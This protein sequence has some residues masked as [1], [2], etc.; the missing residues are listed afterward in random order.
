MALID[1]KC[2]NDHIH[3][4]DRP[5]K[6]WPATPPCPTC[7]APTEQFHAPRS[8]TWTLDPVVVYQAPDGSMRFPGATDA[9]STSKYDRA[10]FTRIE[11]RSAADVRRF[12]SHM[13]KHERAIASRRV[14]QMHRMH[15]QRLSQTRGNLRMAMQS[16]SA[17]GRDVARAAMNQTNRKSNFQTRDPGFHVDVF[18]NNRSSRDESRDSSGRRRR[19]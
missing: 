13:N 10:G 11:L 4:V 8:V 2:P 15:E 3:E 6:D 1:V 16:M 12:E 19:D 18:S 17:M 7:S 9:L 5:A 14:E